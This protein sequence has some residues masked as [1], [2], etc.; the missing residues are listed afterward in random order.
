MHCAPMR[1]SAIVRRFDL[2]LD[3]MACQFFTSGK[4]ERSAMAG[5]VRG[6]SLCAQIGRLFRLEA[7]RLMLKH[8]LMLPDR[9]AALP[10]FVERALRADL[11]QYNGTLHIT[12]AELGP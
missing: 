9:A 10:G 8:E 11:V 2:A 6:I 3:L 12:L 4:L 7:R 5:S 1:D